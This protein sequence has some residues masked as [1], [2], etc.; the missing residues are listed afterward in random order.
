[1]KAAP[2][3]LGK[4]GSTQVLLEGLPGLSCKRLFVQLPKRFQGGD[5]STGKEYSSLL[6][7]VSS[8]PWT[9]VLL[10]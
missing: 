6:S 7:P 10:Q 9:S 2:R 8:Q 4:G 1:M 3:V 5:R